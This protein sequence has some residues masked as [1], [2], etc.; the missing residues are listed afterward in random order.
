M[1][2]DASCDVE[3][4]TQ[5]VAA[6]QWLVHLCQ[7]GGALGRALTPLEEKK[8]N[9]FFELYDHDKTFKHYH[10]QAVHHS[11]SGK[12][13]RLAQ[14]LLVKDKTKRLLQ[15]DPFAL[16]IAIK[17]VRIEPSCLHKSIK[18]TAP[19]LLDTAKL[20]IEHGAVAN[21]LDE[22]GNSALFY[23]CVLGYA[24]LFKLL[25]ESGADFSTTHQRRIPE[26]LRRLK[27]DDSEAN[28]AAPDNVNL[29]QTTL[30]SLISPQRITD[31][32]WIGYPPGMNYDYHIWKLDL[33]ATWGG[34]VLELMR[35]GLTCAPDDL[36]L[37]KLL[38]V[39]CNQ[40]ALDFVTPLLEFGASINVPDC[41][42]IAETGREQGACNGTALHSAAAKWQIPTAKLLLQHGADAHTTRACRSYSASWDLTPV[43]LALNAVNGKDEDKICKALEFCELMMQAETSLDGKDYLEVLNFCAQRSRLEF[44]RRLLQRGVRPPTMPDTSSLDVILLLLEHGVKIDPPGLQRKAMERNRLPILRWSVE[45]HGGLLSSDPEGWGAIVFRAA[46]RRPLATE[47]LKFLTSEYPGPHV[48]SVLQIRPDGKRD[49]TLEKTNLLQIVLGGEDVK[50]VKIALDAGADPRCPGLP[51]DTL[52]AFQRM[53]RTSN[54]TPRPDDSLQIIRLLQDKMLHGTLWTPPSVTETRAKSKEVIETQKRMWD[55]RIERLVQSRCA[56][57][58]LQSLKLSQSQHTDAITLGTRHTY[59]YKDLAGTSSMRLLELLP[60]PS[61]TSP[62]EFRLVHSDITHQPQYEALSYVWGDPA[63]ECSVSMD[64]HPVSVTQNLHSALVHLRHEIEVRKL[65]IDALCINQRDTSERNQQVVIMGDIYRRATQVL[66]WLGEAADD[67][68]LVFARIKE[69][70]DGIMNRVQPMEQERRAWKALITRPW[71]FRT[72]VIQEVALNT[73]K[74]IIICGDDSARWLDLGS[75]KSDISGGASGLG[76]ARGHA[77]K[78]AYHPIGGVDFNSRIYYLRLMDPGHHPVNIMRYSRM[79]QSSDIKDRV[80]G[81]LGLFE[82]GFM[83]IDYKLPVEEIFRRFVEASIKLKGELS[84]L[85]SNGSQRHLSSLPSWVP[86]LSS[87]TPLG[88]LPTTYFSDT[89]S[90]C[91]EF[92]LRQADGS[93]TTIASTGFPKKIL[94][95]LDFRADGALVVRGKLVDTITAIGPELLSGIA[96]APK[97][98]QEGAEAEPGSFAHVFREWE[99]LAVSLIPTWGRFL[100]SS[101]TDAFA[102]TLIADQGE[103]GDTWGRPDRAFCEHMEGFAQWYRLCGTGVLEAADPSGYLRD[104]EFFMHWA[105][106]EAKHAADSLAEGKLPPACDGTGRMWSIPSTTGAST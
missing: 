87:T 91:D 65:W 70:N 96:Y 51:E 17:A 95:G 23:T 57:P 47:M 5:A 37:V 59:P 100:P 93:V 11:L 44:L 88:T 3:Q 49:S 85:Q 74:T 61:R 64:G 39:S 36:G 60:S 72:W 105:G 67:S 63:M 75:S 104:V 68:H 52:T 24:E 69:V 99:S 41:R 13:Y 22:D 103:L 4:K 6:G 21:S 20:L 83:T 86:D 27:G 8:F 48:D 71:F 35:K 102:T 55:A 77:K 46:V 31:F 30:D 56:I 43:G 80:Y 106:T 76:G 12:D 82:P 98:Y 7:K 58:T 1:S 73:R 79:C 45:K 18:E 54:M 97:R 15:D 66:V 16:Q 32:S 26:Q 29:L 84:I 19:R 40:G 38:H 34:I 62:I 89:C 78:N 92:I 9:E 33:E 81:V 53:I 28:G 50:T 90:R 10:I 42:L 2:D 25:C 14:A 101:V 94:P